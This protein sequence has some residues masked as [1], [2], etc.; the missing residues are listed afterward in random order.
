MRIHVTFAALL[1]TS[2]LFFVSGC[3]DQTAA[4]MA[5]ET[6]ESGYRQAKQL[7]RQGRPQE[8]LSFYL[9]VVA[10]RSESAPESHLEAGL[11]YLQDIKDPIAAIYHFRKYLE[12][13]PNSWQASKVRGLVE[14]AKREF[15][16]T[17]PASP[18]DNQ[19]G[20]MEF[21]DQME[22]LQRENDQLK[23]EIATLHGNAPVQPALARPLS[24]PD[25]TAGPVSVIRPTT[26]PVSELGD[27]SSV[28]SI[29]MANPGVQNPP[30]SD[31]TID[32]P[33]QA[34][35]APT[36]PPPS[37]SRRKHT[38]AKGDTL[39]SL[40]QR[41]YGNRSRWRDIYAANRD[42]MRA[43]NDLRIGMELRIP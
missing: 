16:R 41:Y 43:E 37:A 22:R 15:A 23:A 34:P 1:A 20:R 38:V 11:I 31:P 21:I 9:K 17:L 32:A 12:L 29:L 30:V 24:T 39:F 3:D 26:V 6:D 14:T 25:S 35:T 36:A 2:V 28:P 8:A 27:N 33:R 19:S 4:P 18:L 5:A 40:A 7:E 13:Q 10:K 42:T